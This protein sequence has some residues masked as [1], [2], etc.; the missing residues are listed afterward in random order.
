MSKDEPCC[1][2]IWGAFKPE[3]DSKNW[4]EV[5]HFPD[6]SKAFDAARQFSSAGVWAQVES[7]T[8]EVKCSLVGD[9]TDLSSVRSLI[10]RYSGT[11]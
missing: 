10:D 3:L 1:L 11:A 8:G 4:W 5:A 6:F 2:K 9:N 7:M